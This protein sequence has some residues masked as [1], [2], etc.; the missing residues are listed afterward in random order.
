MFVRKVMFCLFILI[1]YNRKINVRKEN[2]NDKWVR[3]FREEFDYFYGLR[4]V[5][6]WCRFECCYKGG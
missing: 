6:W 4:K 2:N 3:G 1:G 5:S